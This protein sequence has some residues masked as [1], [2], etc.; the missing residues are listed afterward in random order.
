MVATVRLGPRARPALGGA[1]LLRRG[2]GRAAL[3]AEIELNATLNAL[4]AGLG[5]AYR[6]HRERVMGLL[7]AAAAAAGREHLVI[8]G[9]GNCNDVDLTELSEAFAAVTLVD[10]DAAAM[11]RAARPLGRG[12]RARLSRHALDLGVADGATARRVLGDAG[13]AASVVLSATLLTQLIASDPAPGGAAGCVRRR[14]LTLMRRLLAPGARAI[15]VTDLVSSAQTGALCGPEAR[16]PGA[17][18]AECCAVGDYFAG[19][20]PRDVLADMA[21]LPDLAPA[22]L[23]R[24]APWVWTIEDPYAY[25]VYAAAFARADHKREGP[26]S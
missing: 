10:I 24:S 16:R 26:I 1:R 11:A 9:A 23:R 4:T 8:L 19:T 14:H 25:L 20:R 7:R 21:A 15:L 6:P 22:S 5:E 13:R 3:H 17:V 2:R 12:A 18:L